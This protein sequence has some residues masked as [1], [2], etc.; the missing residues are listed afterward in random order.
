MKI[1]SPDPGRDIRLW[2]NSFFTDFEPQGNLMHETCTFYSEKD[3]NIF[4]GRLRS[5][6]N[7]CGGGSREHALSG[8][9]AFISFIIQK[10]RRYGK[11]WWLNSTETALGNPDC[12]QECV[13][14]LG[15]TSTST[16]LQLR[17]RSSSAAGAS[18][19]RN[20]VTDCYEPSTC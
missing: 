16:F 8:L 11:T 2:L 10:K 20:V 17:N 13:V 15:R 1:F 12:A 9:S 4:A 18:L 19:E 6:I 7:R 3:P 5:V 14:H